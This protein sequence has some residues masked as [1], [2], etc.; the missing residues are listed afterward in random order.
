M[1]NTNEEKSR[2]FYPTEVELESIKKGLFLMK[3]ENRTTYHK[4]KDIWSDNLKFKSKIS[5]QDQFVFR[6]VA[7]SIPT[8]HEEFVID[9]VHPIAFVF[10]IQCDKNKYGKTIIT[11]LD[12]NSIEWI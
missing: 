4:W 5:P 1:D 2:Y 10:G 12:D 8:F 7:I 11:R 9:S 6:A 3:Y